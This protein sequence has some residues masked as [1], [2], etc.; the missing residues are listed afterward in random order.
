MK[1]RKLVI[2]LEMI[3]I[4]IIGLL[5]A[6]RITKIIED[7]PT[8]QPIVI[9]EKK[10]EKDCCKAEHEHNQQ[11]KEVITGMWIK[12]LAGHIPTITFQILRQ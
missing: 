3:S 1:T 7:T 8:Q 6:Q 2:I 5:L 10:E 11:T 4:G 9:E 12:V